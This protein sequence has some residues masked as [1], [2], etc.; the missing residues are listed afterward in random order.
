MHRFRLIDQKLNLKVSFGPLVMGRLFKTQF[1][2]KN[3]YQKLFIE[4]HIFQL[5]DQKQNSKGF[6]RPLEMPRV[7]MRFSTK[8]FLAKIFIKM[9][10]FQL[11]HYKLDS[12]G[13]FWTPGDGPFVQNSISY[14]K[15]L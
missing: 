5:I 10:R 4:M 13:F 1:P 12:K 3:S 7:K 14:K 6:Y 9:H 8:R 2:I 15:F 11:I